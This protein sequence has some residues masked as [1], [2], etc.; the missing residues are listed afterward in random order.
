[1][2]KK[3]RRKGHGYERE[4][5]KRHRDIGFTDARRHMEMHSGEAW[6]RRDLSG[7]EPFA[8]QCK[9]WAKPPPITVIEDV[10]PHGKYRVPL[11][12]L[13]R[14]R[15]QGKGPLEVVVVPTDVWLRIVQ[16]LKKN[17]LLRDIR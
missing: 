4:I 15:G 16:L 13:K 3:S 8:I 10:R 7:T 1:M 5:A 11:A 6:Q 2:G 14:T 9:A 12:F 17:N